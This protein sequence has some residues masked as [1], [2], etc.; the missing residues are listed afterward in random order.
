MR[1]REKEIF[2]IL[3]RNTP[4]QVFFL[5]YGNDPYR[6]LVSVILSASSTDRMAVVSAERLFA[7]FP[8]LEDVA[9]ADEE[10]IRALIHS[11]GL[12][13]T[14]AGT[15]RRVSEYIR[16]RGLP[17]TRNELL[18]IRG[19]GEKTAS[20]YVQKVLSEPSVVVDTHFERVSYRLSLSSSHDRNRTM[21]EIEKT[22]DKS[23]WSRLSDCVNYLGRTFCRPSP[24]CGECFLEEK[25]RKR[26][27]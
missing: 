17:K 5:P 8:R 16:D 6:F 19:I 20:C 27:D 15:I 3:D 1:E 11:S 4:S 10:S 9:G 7:R 22:F 25:C 13:A 24:R 26:F 14:K 18:S 12:A 21:R 23:C 2:T